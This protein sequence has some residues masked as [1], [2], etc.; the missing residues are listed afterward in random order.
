MYDT[1]THLAQLQNYLYLTAKKTRN[2]KETVRS[3]ILLTALMFSM[4]IRR[5][6]A[7]SVNGALGVMCFCAHDDTQ[8]S[9]Q[10]FK[11]WSHVCT[12]QPL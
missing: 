10:C 3:V 1:S 7:V 6:K 8:F 12:Q 9:L 4:G 5:F 11:A 2:I